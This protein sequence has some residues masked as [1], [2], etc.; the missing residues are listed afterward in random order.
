MKYNIN[1]ENYFKKFNILSIVI[2][3]V[4]IILIVFKGLNYGIDFKGGTLLEISIN[5]DK[6][7]IGEIRD[8]LN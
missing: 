4:S 5:N 8:S 7:K 6:I 1:F 2:F 3:F